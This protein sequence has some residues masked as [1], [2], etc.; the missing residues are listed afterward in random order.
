MSGSERSDA[1]TVARE[2]ESVREEV[3]LAEVLDAFP[4][5]VLILDKNRQIIHCNKRFTDSIGVKRPLALGKRPG[6]VFGCIHACVM[7]AGCG[8]S[9]F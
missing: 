2:A 7:P 6:E 1:Q 4:E 8:T 9:R 3:L 5:M